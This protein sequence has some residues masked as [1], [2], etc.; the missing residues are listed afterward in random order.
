MVCGGGA[1]Q[2]RVPE[3]I[4][5]TPRRHKV[6]RFVYQR[7]S[8]AEWCAAAGPKPLDPAQ[9]SW[10]ARVLT[11]AHRSCCLSNWEATFC[12]DVD[13]RLSEWGERL[14]L[15]DKQRAVL[16]KIAARLGVG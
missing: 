1:G 15:S 10:L 7:R 3:N 6:R 2:H 13:R 12:L 8:R 5:R 16:D 14:T 11:A 4:A 9:V